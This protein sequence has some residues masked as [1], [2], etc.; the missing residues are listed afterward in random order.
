MASLPRPPFPF[1]SFAD[2]SFYLTCMHRREPHKFKKRYAE[3][4]D[5]DSKPPSIRGSKYGRNEDTASY[6]L[7]C[8]AIPAPFSVKPLVNIVRVGVDI[9]SEPMRVGVI[10]FCVGCCFGFEIF[11]AFQSGVDCVG[12][13]HSKHP[14]HCSLNPS[15]PPTP[16]PASSHSQH[17]SSY[18]QHAPSEV[19]VLTGAVLRSLSAAAG[20][21]GFSAAAFLLL[22]CFF[23]KPL[24]L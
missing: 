24:P 11:G 20:F 1:I 16:S 12:V 18:S 8:V 19:L 13:H 2:V 4:A 22:I 5:E 9:S 23:S 3:V 6:F 7:L 10:L 14:P 15:S 17:T 21:L